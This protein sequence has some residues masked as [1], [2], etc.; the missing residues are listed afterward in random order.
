MLGT[1]K[2]PKNMKLITG[3]LPESNYESDRP[4]RSKNDKSE[5]RR[6]DSVLDEIA[7]DK[8]EDQD[9]LLSGA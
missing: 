6:N 3:T 2:L 8:E 5:I 1:I 7:E 9:N 4:K